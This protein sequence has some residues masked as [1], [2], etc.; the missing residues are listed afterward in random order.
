MEF[1]I[2][3]TLLKLLSDINPVEGI[4]HVS[5]SSR[6]K[7][8]LRK[9][10]NQIPST[11]ANLGH[12]FGTKVTTIL[13][14]AATLLSAPTFAADFP[15]AKIAI[16]DLQSVLD[17][18]VAVKHLRQSIDDVS[19]KF[20]KELSS[21]ELEFKQ[22]EAE[23]VKK[24]GVLKQEVFDL[25]VEG[26][27]KKL[28][29]FQHET[30]KKKEKLERAH[31]EAI[32]TVHAQTIAIVQEIAKTKGFT[33]AIPSSHTLYYQDSINITAEVTHK[34]NQKVMNVQLKY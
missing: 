25:E 5:P 3:N 30:Q 14:V 11:R 13:V 10:D 4:S 18:S 19:E 15:T 28:S 27:Y 34:L 33:I 2:R 31:A 6:I 1:T 21:K 26:F 12:S 20:S 29:A 23:L 24:R 17:N 8:T 32:D 16:V 22:T 7:Y 9:R